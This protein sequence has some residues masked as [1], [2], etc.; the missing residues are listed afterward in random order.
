MVHV[1]ATSFL[2][3]LQTLIQGSS[4]AIHGIWSVPST[5]HSAQ[6]NSA[7]AHSRSSTYQTLTPLGRQHTR[8]QVRERSLCCS[9]W[10]MH[11]RLLAACG[12]CLFAAAVLAA[13]K[14]WIQPGC[15]RSRHAVVM[16]CLLA[17]ECTSHM[18]STHPYRQNCAVQ[19]QHACPLHLPLSLT[20]HPLPFCLCWL[21]CSAFHGDPAS[22][23]SQLPGAA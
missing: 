2:P 15:A 1:A 10:R 20:E 3:L 23:F 9:D 19:G 6:H 17:P 13:S 11:V 22:S 14:D 5:T 8:S 12:C 4:D 7:T 16:H 21:R 18:V